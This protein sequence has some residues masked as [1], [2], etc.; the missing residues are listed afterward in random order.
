LKSHETLEIEKVELTPEKTIIYLSIENRIE[1]GAFCAD[2]NIYLIFPDGEKSKL[3]KT[4]GIPVCPASYK[5]KSIGEKLRFTLVFPPPKTGTAW[6]DI[7]EEC[8]ENCFSF[9]GVTLNSALNSKIDEALVFAETGK[10]TAALALYKSI[11]ENLDGL[12]QGIK[13]AL[14]SDIITLSLEIGDK[15]GAGEWYKKLISSNV[16]HLQLIVQNLN[17]RGIKF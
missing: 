6:V 2:R 13:G 11:L 16:P 3:E 1:N 15:A 5:F 8:N 9:Y 7:I 12:D 17:S 10:K 14:Y 4:S